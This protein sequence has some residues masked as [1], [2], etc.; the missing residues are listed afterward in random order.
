MEDSR[1]A[2]NDSQRFLNSAQDTLAVLESSKKENRE[3]LK[4]CGMLE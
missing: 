2:L 4:P 1:V 3:R